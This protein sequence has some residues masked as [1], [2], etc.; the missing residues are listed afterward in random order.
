M[1]HMAL[2][3]ALLLLPPF[4][5]GCLLGCGFGWLR[6]GRGRRVDRQRSGIQ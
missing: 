2:E 3:L 5:L 4:L 6:R 1:G